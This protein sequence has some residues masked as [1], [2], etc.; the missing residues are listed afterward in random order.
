MLTR[1]L[2]AA[3]QGAQY[4]QLADGSW[5]GNIPGFSGLWSD[6]ESQESCRDELRD[7]L[8]DWV[9]FS[10]QRGRTLPVMDGIDLTITEVA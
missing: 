4:E 3:M 7:A 2:E 10:L 1:Y 6:G 9:L 8:E 5:W